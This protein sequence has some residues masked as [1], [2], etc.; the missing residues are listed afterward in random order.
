MHANRA[1][2][3]RA[4]G[5][6]FV[7]TAHRSMTTSDVRKAIRVLA[8]LGTAFGVALYL[9]LGPIPAVMGFVP[10]IVLGTALA[11]SQRQALARE[12]ITIKGN[13]LLVRQ[14][15]PH[16]RMRS[17]RSLNLDHLRLERIEDPDLGCLRIVAC[18]GPDRIVIGRALLADER[19]DFLQALV[20]SLRR[21][22]RSPPI[23]PRRLA[24]FAPDAN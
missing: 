2:A 20:A 12:E 6:C 24:L 5:D 16:G 14:V 13:Q 11:V 3:L 10:L 1:G 19:S 21:A 17:E 23:E 4:P 15:S 7:I 8:V 22:G 9:M 18:S